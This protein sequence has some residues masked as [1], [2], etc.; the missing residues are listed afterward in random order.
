MSPHL[1]NELILATQSLTNHVFSDLKRIRFTTSHPNDMT[2]SLI[3]LFGTEEKL[4]PYLHL[5][6]QSGSDRVLKA[7]NRRHSVEHYLRILDVGLFV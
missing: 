6:I 7:M 3:K 2:D 5:P 4:M 1:G